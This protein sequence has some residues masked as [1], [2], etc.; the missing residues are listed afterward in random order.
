MLNTYNP[1]TILDKKEELLKEL[2]KIAEHASV[3][4]AKQDSHAY[5]I[6][7][8]C[9]ITVHPGLGCPNNCLYCYLIDF[10]PKFQE[11]KPYK[12]SGFEVSLSLLY[13]KWF[14]PG[15]MGT[16]IAI[17]SVCEPFHPIF[18]EKTIDYLKS[19]VKYLKNPIQF[20]TKMFLDAKQVHEVVEAVEKH[21]LSPLITI[22][23]IKYAKSL[24]PNVP[25]PD[26]RFETISNLRD[27]G[28]KPV[29]FLRPIIPGVTDR[30]FEQIFERASDAGAV[31]VVIGTLRISRKILERLKK[32]QIDLHPI[33]E[34]AAKIGG[35]QVHL[36]IADL[37][38]EALKIAK[39]FK[40]VPFRSACCA[41]AF[42]ASIPCANVCW[43]TKF[44]TNCPNNCKQKRIHIT[45]EK[46][47]HTIEKILNTQTFN[48]E[49][50]ENHVKIVIP[51]SNEKDLKTKRKGISILLK[52]LLRRR[53]KITFVN[54]QK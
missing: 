17:G 4:K 38:E 47:N 53:V 18:Y 50:N 6:P 29:L 22:I 24:E 33:K 28:F 37:K 52:T 20:S 15:E 51:K 1:I 45:T 36:S 12:L 11:P 43:A 19:F 26:K 32:A 9:G 8:P 39:E 16:F 3:K 30:E 42:N 7:R 2:E 49:V 10:G 35:K 54:L 34:R 5:R 23:T 31:G 46:I 40:L 41:N 44:C 21:P 27:A 13:N 14:I 25:T 48:S